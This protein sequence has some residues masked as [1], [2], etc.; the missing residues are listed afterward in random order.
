MNHQDH[1]AL[2]RDAI[3]GKT[4]AELGAGGGA[5]TLALAECLPDDGHITAIDKNKR[6]VHSLPT[7]VMARY[8]RI[9][10][11]GTHADFTQALHLAD[12]DGIL[13]ANA[14]HFVRDVHKVTVLRQL[15]GYLK[16]GG[17]MVVVEYNVDRGNVWVP[18][19]FSYAT[20]QQLASDAGLVDTRQVASRPSSFLKAFYSAV[21]YRP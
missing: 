14:L 21:S 19:P 10:V 7:M 3:T 9:S 16:S 1:I 17:A 12:L 20:W 5:F 4:W 15:A 13:M 2:I 8:P 6:A 11:Q 18:H